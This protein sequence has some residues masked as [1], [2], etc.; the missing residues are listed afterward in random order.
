V[1]EAQNFSRL[2]QDWNSSAEKQQWLAGANHEM[3]L[4]SRLLYRLKE[5]HAEFTAAAG[6]SPDMSLA[7]SI[8]G[9]ESALALYDIGEL[10][11]LYVTRLGSAR[12]LESL[13]W[14]SRANFEPRNAAGRDY[15]VRT[16]AQSGRQAVFAATDDYLLLATAEEPLA[17]ALTLLAGQGGPAVTADAWFSDAT[18]ASQGRGELRLTLNMEA[19]SQSPHFRSYWVQRNVPDLQQYRSAVIDLHREEGV[20]REERIFLR[21]TDFLA[22]PDESREQ[23]LA[24]VLRLAPPQAGLYRAWAAPQQAQVL[25]LLRQ[26]LLDP[27]IGPGPSSGYAPQVFLGDGAVGSLA[28]GSLAA[29]ETRIDEPPPALATGRFSSEALENLFA[30]NA[31]AAMLHTESSR[32]GVEGVFVKSDV[33]IA[34]LGSSDWELL[35]VFESVA[36]SIRGGLTVS[37][38]GAGWTQQSIGAQP[39]YALTGV[40]SLFFAVSGRYLLVSNS[41][42]SLGAVLTRMTQP[43]AEPGASFAAGLRHGQERGNYARLMSHLDF[44]QGGQVF[45]NQQREPYFFSENIASLSQALVRVDSVSRRVRDEGDSVSDTVIYRIEP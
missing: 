28:A 12:A 43:A 20:I 18:Q 4:R 6:F 30:E 45:G 2:L 37:G 41:L 35:S 25:E 17:Q 21:G 7:E 22:S 44:L 42:A 36:N 29:L 10:R 3:F 31:V 39:A 9:G 8:A 5:A 13:L 15:Y 33:V 24:Q 1:L 34:L 14:Q 19:L 23:A 32:S 11:F 27:S 38:I 26:K 16:D 40:D